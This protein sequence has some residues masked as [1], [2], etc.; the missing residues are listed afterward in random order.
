MIREISGY[1][2]FVKSH[3]LI[4]ENVPSQILKGNAVAA[5]CAA[6]TL[7]LSI[8]SS[9][10]ASVSEPRGMNDRGA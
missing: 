10:D 6:L 9:S 4:Q 8:L 3:P 2:A 5:H 1:R 7:I